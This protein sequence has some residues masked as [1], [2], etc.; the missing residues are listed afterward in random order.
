MSGSIAA[1]AVSCRLCRVNFAGSVTC[2]DKAETE[3]F[4][5]SGGL[6]ASRIR[7]CYQGRQ[8]KGFCAE[9]CSRFSTGTCGFP[10]KIV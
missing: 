1:C 8:R 10:P 6:N 9:I 3:A 4:Q 2:S 5:A 7:R